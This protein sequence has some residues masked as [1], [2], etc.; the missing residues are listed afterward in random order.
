MLMIAATG[1][2][3]SNDSACPDHGAEIPL[4]AIPSPLGTA[5]CQ[6]QLAHMELAELD[7]F[8]IRVRE[9]HGNSAELDSDAVQHL[10]NLAG[11]PSGPQVVVI[12]PT[13]DAALNAARMQ[14]VV[15]MLTQ[16]NVLD[17]ESR[18]MIQRPIAEGM[19]GAEAPRIAN[20]YL[21][22]GANVGQGMQG[23]VVGGTQQG[24]FVGGFGGGG[25]F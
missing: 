2:C 10:M 6:W 23:G 20:G 19:Y 22:G 11:R 8:V 12:E 17:A 18:V 9:W 15:R 24:G 5:A 25:Y 3:R 13:S 1:G 14:E 7:D 16:F 21:G 4:G